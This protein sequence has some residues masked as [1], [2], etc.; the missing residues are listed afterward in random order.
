M[1]STVRDEIEPDP[2]DFEFQP[3]TKHQEAMPENTLK[4]VKPSSALEGILLTIAGTQARHLQQEKIKDPGLE[5]LQTKLRSFT[6]NVIKEAIDAS[7]LDH[8]LQ[9][10]D[11]LLQKSKIGYYKEVKPPVCG[12]QETWDKMELQLISEI[13]IDSLK[14]R[15]TS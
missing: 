6:P 7:T 2:T 15:N 8:L 12:T 3:E 13:L 10:Q 9:A 5:A 1:T 4:Q 14:K 11:N